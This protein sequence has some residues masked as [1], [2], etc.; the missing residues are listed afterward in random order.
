MHPQEWRRWAERW[1]IG[2]Q[3]E[4]DPLYC[5]LEDERKES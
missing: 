5:W 2:M 4:E 1:V 3:C